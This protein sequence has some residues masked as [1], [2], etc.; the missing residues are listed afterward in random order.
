[1]THDEW[2]KTLAKNWD[3]YYK[4]DKQDKDRM[5]K[6]CTK[7]LKCK[8]ILIIGVTLVLNSGKEISA[9]KDCLDSIKKDDEYFK[10]INQEKE[11]ALKCTRCG[12]Y[13]T[14]FT[15][16][17]DICC[18]GD[19]PEFKEVED[20]F[21]PF[22]LEKALAGEEVI[23][24]EPKGR[25]IKEILYSKTMDRVIVIT[26]I[27]DAWS[28]YHYSDGRYLSNETTC[29]DLFMAPKTPKKGWINI[30]LADNKNNYIPSVI[31]GKEKDAIE[32]SKSP[33][34]HPAIFIKTIVLDLGEE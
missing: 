10:S 7:C 23:F 17:K 25:K 2:V 18:L 33:G 15:T 11:M 24:R 6:F 4:S 32:N 34:M 9:C 8:K 31:Y 26:P 22:D 28:T 1:M 21:I 12:N 20:S 13:V 5:L 19:E 16:R 14:F 30:F 29:D 27:G 3:E